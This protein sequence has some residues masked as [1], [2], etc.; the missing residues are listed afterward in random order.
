M[1]LRLNRAVFR[2][3]SLI[4]GGGKAHNGWFCSPNWGTRH[5]YFVS[6]KI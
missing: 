1:A 5:Y 3:Q 2:P 6:L 4:L